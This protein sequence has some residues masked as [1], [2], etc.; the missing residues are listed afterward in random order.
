[1]EVNDPHEAAPD[2]PRSPSDADLRRQA[3]RAAAAL[4]PDLTTALISVR[5]YLRQAELMSAAIA[6][7]KRAAV[8]VLYA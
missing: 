5:Y 3:S 2:S 4:R 7:R 1:M 6:A 8:L